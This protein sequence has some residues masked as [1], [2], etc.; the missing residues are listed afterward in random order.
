MS[1]TVSIVCVTHGRPDLV[2]K[3]MQSCVEQD[4]P[5]KEI[6]LLFN[7][8]DE[9]TEATVRTRFPEIKIL[10]TDHNLGFF[11][12]LNV[13]IASSGGDYVMIV[14]DDAWFLGSDALTRLVGYFRDEPELG[15]VTCNLEGPNEHPITDGDRYIRVFTTG[16]TM[17]P[18]QV[19]TEWVG[20]IPNLF[21]RSAGETYWCTQLWEQRR[22][23]KRV[24]NVRMFH[25]LAM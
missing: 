14:D 6:V 20:P 17:I 9:T 7:P 8:A 23:V 25:A 12:A 10:T 1:E 18:R 22:P 19:V 24:E 2:L 11:P 3:C 5:K 21:F 13:A 16:F 15:A 4:Y